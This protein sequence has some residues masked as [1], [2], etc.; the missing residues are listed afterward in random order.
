MVESVVSALEVSMLFSYR[1]YQ[2]CLQHPNLLCDSPS[3]WSIDWTS[4]ET[5]RGL[6]RL[7]HN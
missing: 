7:T 4:A 1:S 6:S 5:S 3:H 2:S